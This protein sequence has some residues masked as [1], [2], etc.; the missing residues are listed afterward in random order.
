MRRM[1]TSIVAGFTMLPQSMAQTIL[2]TRVAASPAG[3]YRCMKGGAEMTG[4]FLA[5]GSMT[6]KKKLT[7]ACLFL[8]AAIM[9]MAAKG[10]FLQAS[11]QTPKGAT[12]AA[13]SGGDST[14]TKGAACVLA[15]LAMPPTPKEIPGYTQL[16]TTTGLHVTG[17]MKEIDVTQYRLEVIGKVARPL[18]LSYEEIRCMPR[19]EARPTLIC[20]GFFTDVATWAG[21]PLKY[22]VD[23]AGPQEGAK[24]LRLTGADSHTATLSLPEATRPGN[25]LAYEWEG[26][27]LPRLHGFPIRAVFPGLEGNKWVKWVIKIEVL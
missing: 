1:G 24:K 12:K 17:T 21:T 7:L 11:D 26:K 13:A 20:P 25:F 27:A 18:R 2:C 19:I 6:S 16:D 14:S 5:K 10:A 15:P 22:I 9:A 23:L 3:P 4:R 8:V